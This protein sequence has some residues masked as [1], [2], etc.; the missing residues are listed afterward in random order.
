[1]L[2]RTNKDATVSIIIPVK[3][4]APV[5]TKCLKSIFDLSLKNVD[6]IVVDDG[7]IPEAL[8]KI[9]SLA[10]SI[11]ILKSNGRGPSY[12]RNLGAKT[13]S[14]DFIVFI[15]SDCI[16]DCDCI[17]CLLKGFT[18]YPEAAACGGSQH[19]PH[20]ASK[21]EKKVYAFMKRAGFVSEYVRMGQKTTIRKVKHNASCNVMYRR[22]IFLK[23]GGFL[24][25]L[26][27]GEDVELD[28]RLIRKGY[29][30]VFNP[31]AIVY[32]YKPKNITLFFKMMYRYGW[33]QGVMVK[34]YGIFRKVQVVPIVSCLLIGA[35]IWSACVDKYLVGFSLALIMILGFLCLGASISVFAL[36]LIGS[37]GWHLGFIKGVFSKN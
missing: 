27:P 21:F 37:F 26:W 13:S 19:I 12:A 17:D 1:M 32:H 31:Q 33:A 2:E 6:I 9:E 20:D 24:E 34:K 3:G 29:V 30:L 18:R 16:A 5:L 14:S 11:K 28:R 10:K 23:E 35:L 25:G 4:D 15:D 36:T 22:D 7:I 8:G